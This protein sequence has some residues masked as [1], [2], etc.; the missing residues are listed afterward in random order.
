MTEATIKSPCILVCAIEPASGHCYGCGR[1]REEIAD[2]INY[3][4]KD[5]DRIMEVLPDRVAKLERKP[6][7]VTRRS[8]QRGAVIRRNAFDSETG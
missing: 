5:R 2:W 3:T 8:R 6:R 4:V 7:R 1:S